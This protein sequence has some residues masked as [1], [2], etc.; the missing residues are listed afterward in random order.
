MQLF[1]RALDAQRNGRFTEAETLYRR[2][3]AYDSNNFDALHMLGIVCYE[4]GKVSEA[5]KF[6]QKALSIDTKFPP[7]FHHYGLFL[8]KQQRYREAVEQFDEAL[9]L[10][11]RFA[12]VYSDRGIALMELG[13]LDEAMVSHNRAVTLAPNAPMAVYNRAN[14]LFKKSE[15]VL[16]LEDYK[17]AV[18]LGG[19]YAD[20]YCGTG[21]ALR[22]LKRYSE[23]LAAYQRAIEIA[24][25]LPEAWLGRGTLFRELGRHETAFSDFDRAFK[26][27]PDLPGVMGDR[28]HAKL[29][30]CD[31][32]NMTAECMHLISSVREGHRGTSPFPF[33]TVSSSAEDQLK[34]AKQWLTTINARRPGSISQRDCRQNDRIRIAYVSADFR[35]H[36]VASL[37]VGMLECH[38]KSRFDVTGISFGKND[39]SA[40][41]GRVQSSLEHF[42][43]V[44]GESER[45]LWKLLKDLEIDIAVDMMGFTADSRSDIFALRL[46]PVQVN[47]LGYPGTMGVPY[48]DY[49]I[50]DRIVVPKDQ[51]NCYSEA[52]A[53]LPNSF[54]PG[55][56]ARTADGRVFTRADVGLPVDS[57][58]FCCFNNP[59]KIT[60]DVFDVWMRILRQIGGSVLWLFSQNPTAERNLRREAE[61]RGVSAERIINAPLLPFVEHQSR[62]SQADLFLDTSPYNGGAVVSDALWAGLPVV[63]LI[64]STLVGRM[65]ASLL[66]AINLPELITTNLGDYE[67]LVCTLAR[68]SEQLAAIRRKLEK[69]RL[70]TPLFDSQCFAK[71][72]EAAYLTMW[73]RHQLGEPPQGFATFGE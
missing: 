56:R 64:G 34:C 69:N 23:A 33:L 2:L 44:S 39:N 58:V 54:L 67:S 46:A 50:A 63:T 29:Q 20:A 10:F 15:F 27:K 5:E 21:N 36:S 41:R 18:A 60:P 73:Q 4:N 59:Y 31:W 61:A 13:Q 8:A 68:S 47:F 70:T 42:V 43:D 40:L 22:T 32:S 26:L 11:D 55:D 38:D 25:K 19:N 6:F 66:H 49:I 65:A 3:M 1:D 30:L 51:E 12:P 35:Q 24:P 14:T 9:K 71:H 62:L 16:A 37:I 53:I 17:R 28:L 45:D 72:L 57:F 52:V 48:I 7:L